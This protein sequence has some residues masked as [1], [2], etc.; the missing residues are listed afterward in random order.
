MNRFEAL[1]FLLI[2]IPYLYFL[3]FRTPAESEFRILNAVCGGFHQVHRVMSTAFIFFPSSALFLLSPAASV[4]GSVGCS[5]G[6]GHAAEFVALILRVILF[7][8]PGCESN[9]LQKY[10]SS[11]SSKG[12]DFAIN[13]LNVAL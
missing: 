3:T 8:D 4:S 11:P 9:A 5:K 1:N 7:C 6:G 2:K 10:C 12:V 13:L